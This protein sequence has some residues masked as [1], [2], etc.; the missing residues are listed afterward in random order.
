MTDMS[1]K[2]VELH[3]RRGS[4]VRLATPSSSRS[5][6]LGVLR[7]WR[8]R[9]RIPM[10]DLSRLSPSQLRDLGFLDGKERGR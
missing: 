4:V 9:V 8:E 7:R 10:I 6:L 5:W 1:L 2:R 3:R